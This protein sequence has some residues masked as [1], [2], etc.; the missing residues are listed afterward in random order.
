MTNFNTKGTGTDITASSNASC[1]ACG[2]PVDL[3]HKNVLVELLEKP[4]T[5]HTD[6]IAWHQDC[7][8]QYLDDGEEC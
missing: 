5:Q 3:R 2:K 6:A 4:A 8:D 7:Y 1:H